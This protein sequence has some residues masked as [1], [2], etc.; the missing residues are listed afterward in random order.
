MFNFSRL[1]VVVINLMHSKVWLIVDF[2]IYI[3]L[4]LFFALGYMSN[5]DVVLSMLIYYLICDNINVRYDV[6]MLIEKLKGVE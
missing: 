5:V 6:N 1:D 2:L 4:G 3:N